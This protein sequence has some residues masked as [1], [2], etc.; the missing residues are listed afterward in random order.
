VCSH[1][2]HFIWLGNGFAFVLTKVRRCSFFF[3]DLRQYQKTKPNLRLLSGLFPEN[4]CFLPRPQKKNRHMKPLDATDKRILVLLQENAHYTNKEIAA[5]LGMS[6]TPVYER[7]KRLEEQGYIQRYTA[8]L[9]AHKLGYH[10]VAYCN[11][12]L[13]EHAQ[14]YLQQFETEVQ[15]LAEVVE[16]YHIAGMFDYL[17]KVVVRDMASYQDFIVNKLAA[18]DNIGNVQS[19]FVMTQ[20]KLASGLPLLQG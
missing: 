14:G 17:L 12:Q 5:R 2:Y 15:S 18:L 1:D 6:T 11:V 10:L 13:K 16:C 4:A 3:H 7:I 19:S 8:L 9:D 20:V